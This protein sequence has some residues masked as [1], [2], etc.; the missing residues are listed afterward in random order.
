MV[1]K[2]RMLVMLTVTLATLHTRVG[3]NIRENVK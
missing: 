2:M 3:G 1:G